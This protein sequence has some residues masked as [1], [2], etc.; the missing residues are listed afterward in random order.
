VVGGIEVGLED[1]GGWLGD[2][3]ATGERS[4]VFVRGFCWVVMK[5]KSRIR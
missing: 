3:V 4:V 1:G 2:V 5:K